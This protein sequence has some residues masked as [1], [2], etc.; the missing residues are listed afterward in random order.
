MSAMIFTQTQAFVYKWTHLPTLRWYIGS[1]TAQGCCP[2][3]GYI[4]SSRLVRPL[5]ESAESE[6][7]RTVVATGEPADMLELETVILETVDARSD[8]RSYNQHNG[9]GRFTRVGI[10]PWNTGLKGLKRRPASVECRAKNSALRKEK[11]KTESHKQNLRKVKG[12]QYRITCPHC[13]KVGGASG[14]TR[15][16]YDNCKDSIIDKTKGA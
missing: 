7:T 9:D 12:P 16:H 3:D 13:R 1:R 10:S 2:A 15:Y 6:W 5:V 14:M 11:P 4:C 8:P